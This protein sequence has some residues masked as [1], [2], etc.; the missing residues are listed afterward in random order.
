M[1]GLTG[2]GARV[3]I[4]PDLGTPVQGATVRQSATEIRDD[5][6]ANAVYLVQGET[7]V[8]WI[9]CDVVGLEPNWTQQYR[10]AIAAATGLAERSILISATH[11]HSGPSVVPTTWN[12]ALATGWLEQL[13]GWLVQAAE[14]AMASAQAVKVRMGSGQAQLGYNRRCCWA[15][16]S[17]TMHGNTRRDDFTGLEGPADPTQVAWSIESEEGQVLGVWQQNTTHPTCFYGRPFFSADFPG[18]SRAF[19]RQA[20]GEEALPVLY[21]NGAFGDISIGNMESFHPQGK[22]GEQTMLRV[23]H[24]LTG[25]TLRILHDAPLEEELVL[26]H[27]HED[28]TVEVRLPE[29][30]RLAWAEET[31]AKMV[32]GEEVSNWDQLFAHGVVRLQEAYGDDPTDSLPIHAVRLGDLAMMTQPCELYCQF[33]LDMKRRSPARLNAIGGITD[34]Y[35]GYCPTLSGILGGGYSAEAIYWTRLA[36]EAGYQI[37]DCA[38]RLVRELWN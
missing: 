18:A 23:A 24:L 4:N 7:S 2:G 29:A 12:K 25:E 30:K 22:N 27:G 10:Q 28:L 37:V 36:E 11:T 26:A 16:G 8:L 13:E 3:V 5:L 35:A 6:E 15:D 33:G 32:A 9:A 19:L 17:H 20:L 34:G 21:V 14:A 38:S 1:L 31:I